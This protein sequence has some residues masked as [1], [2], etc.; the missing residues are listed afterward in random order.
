[1]HRT[2]IVLPQDMQTRNRIAGL[3]GFCEEVALG[4]RTHHADEELVKRLLEGVLKSCW[5]RFKPWIEGER[6]VLGAA[7][8]KDLYIELEKL[9]QRWDRQAATHQ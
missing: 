4:V 9:I 5:L 3:L 8:G 2:Q 6:E 1:M 7:E